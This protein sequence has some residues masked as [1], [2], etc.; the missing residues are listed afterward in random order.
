M[1]R[2]ADLVEGLGVLKGNPNSKR[3]QPLPGLASRKRSVRMP[4]VPA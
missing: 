1:E 2:G 3:R 4:G